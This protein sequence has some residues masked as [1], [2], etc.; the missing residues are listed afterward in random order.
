MKRFSHAKGFIIKC[1]VDKYRWK[2]PVINC[3]SNF[4]NRDKK[5]RKLQIEVKLVS[6]EIH[7]KMMQFLKFVL[8][9]KFSKLCQHKSFILPKNYGTNL[10]LKKSCQFNIWAWSSCLLL[11]LFLFK[12][13]SL[14]STDK[15]SKFHQKTIHFPFQKTSNKFKFL[16]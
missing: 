14:L 8:F 12:M 11:R 1:I 9:T 16:S 13:R 15:A 6:L 2:R 4:Y 5:N 3:S 10:F 7:S